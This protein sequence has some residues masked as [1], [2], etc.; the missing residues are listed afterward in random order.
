[1]AAKNISYSE[2][3]KI[4][5]CTKHLL[6]MIREIGGSKHAI[7]VYF[8]LTG[9]YTRNFRRYIVY[10]CNQ[11][12]VCWWPSTERC[13]DIRTHSDEQVRLMKSSQLFHG[14]LPNMI[15]TITLVCPT[16][17]QHGYFILR[18]VEQY[19]KGESAA[20]WDVEVEINHRY[21]THDEKLSLGIYRPVLLI[22]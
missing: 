9:G 12:C 1:M 4:Q 7:N 14:N 17:A 20:C 8:S 19:S 13:W 15:I 22:L 6:H 5:I 11:C 10:C 3:E 2:T 16:P 21:I 18:P